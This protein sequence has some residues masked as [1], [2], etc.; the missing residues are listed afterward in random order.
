MPVVE[1]EVLHARCAGLDIS[2]RDAKCCVRVLPEGKKRPVLDRTCWGATV[3]QVDKLRRHLEDSGVTCVVMEATSTY[4]K[5]FYYGLEGASFEVVLV[6]ARH[7]RQMK[8]RKSDVADAAWLARL[9]AL[10]SVSGSFVPPDLIRGLRLATRRRVTLV[11][12]ATAEASRLEKL[13]EDCCLKLSAVSSKLLTK[14]GRSVLDQICGGVT[15]PAKLAAGSKLR[16]SREDLEEAL[17]NRVQPWHAEMIRS[18][19]R[20]IDHLEAEAA[21][22]EAEIE[23]LVEPFKADRDLL[24][25]VPGVCRTLANDILAEIG[26]D[27][28]VFPSAAH[29]ASWAGVAPGSNESAG[30]VKSARCR[31]GN[32]HLKRAIG[33]A[34]MAAVKRDDNHV[35][36][37]YKRLRYRK[38]HPKALVA[39]MRTMLTAIWHI[40]N[41]GVPYKDL[42]A[43]FYDRRDTERTIA[44]L[45]A[46][47]D[48]LKGEPA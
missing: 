31:D 34:T 20:T 25:T 41:D 40:L 22:A 30:V 29:L 21:A 27:M 48:A 44:R 36:A 32:N 45:Q 38:G 11:G 7:V 8:G 46:R 33:I 28:S 1:E 15:D 23:M 5:P 12:Q 9:A 6:N 17:A 18:H 4:W 10:G 26:P 47:I 19:L 42:G 35:A 13:L 2:K 39:A 43:D 24:E 37:R 3:A 14:T 16:V